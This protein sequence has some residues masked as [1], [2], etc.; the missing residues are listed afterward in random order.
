LDDD[1]RNLV[2]PGIKQWLGQRFR[3]LFITEASRD[4]W[5]LDHTDRYTD[6][7][8]RISNAVPVILPDRR[9]DRQRV[10]EA[11][12]RGQEMA[13]WEIEMPDAAD[14]GVPDTTIVFAP[15]LVNGLLPVR[16]FPTIFPR[17]ARDREWGILRIDLNPLGSSEQ[18]VSDVGR[19]V[20]Q[21]IGF[22]ADLER[23][24]EADAK[25]PENIVFIG[26]SKGTPDIMEFLVQHPEVA[27]RTNAFITWCGAAGGS[28]LVAGPYERIK[29]ME[30]PAIPNGLGQMAEAIVRILVPFLKLDE[31]S[32]ARSSEFDLKGAL[33]SL[34]PSI[35]ENYLDQHAADLDAL[36]IPILSFTGT[37]DVTRVPASQ[38]QGFL[39][40]TDLDQKNDM[41]LTQAAS[42][43]SRVPMAT[44]VARLHANHWDYSFEGWP[45]EYRLT[46]PNLENPFPKESLLVALMQL[47]Q[48]TGIVA[49]RQSA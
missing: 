12:L 9:S 23:I 40:L 5:A 47:L 10:A 43:M 25:P 41:Q 11:Y 34:L 20:F 30:F 39:A 24:L 1:K 6:V 35:R 22:T 2:D 3:N 19:A 29:D 31:K 7:L 17:L 27:E 28:P 48:E 33:R 36:D 21:G 42:T 38:I 44:H 32:L 8:R 4:K 13:E 14:F 26:Y 15:G 16:E 18:N 49:G 45:S 37:T 46:S